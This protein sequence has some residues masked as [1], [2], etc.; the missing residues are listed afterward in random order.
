LVTLVP[1]LLAGG[2]AIPWFS[3][4]AML[5]IVLAVGLLAGTAAVRAVLRAPLLATLRGN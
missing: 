2:A 1:H 3:L 4:G 5:V